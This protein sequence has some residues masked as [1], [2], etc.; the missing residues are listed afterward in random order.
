MFF[1]A[2]LISL[3]IA[4]WWRL[5]ING[6]GKGGSTGTFCYNIFNEFDIDGSSFIHGIYKCVRKGYV[7]DSSDAYDLS[8]T[9][10]DMVRRDFIESQT[11]G[12]M[13]VLKSENAIAHA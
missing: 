8:E 13:T 9:V 2:L 11:G 6:T 7:C 3:F 4:I 12:S 1:F 10:V 5:I